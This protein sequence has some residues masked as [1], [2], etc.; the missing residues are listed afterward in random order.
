M[1]LGINDDI[2]DTA[3]NEGQLADSQNLGDP[4]APGNNTAFTPDWI[5]AFK[6]P[7]HG[8]ILISGDCDLTVEST[9]AQVLCL[10]N[11]G[12]RITLQEILTLKGVVRPGDQKGHEQ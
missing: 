3:F 12:C 11:I 9:H 4:P 6:N 5:N 8:V 2:G 10:F 1:Q 7:I